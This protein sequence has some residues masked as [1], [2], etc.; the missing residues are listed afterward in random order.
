MC[1]NIAAALLGGALL[2]AG[3]A[4]Q[5]LA[6]PVARLEVER[7]ATLPL[8]VVETSGLA[9]H[10][11]RLWTHNDSGDEPRLYEIA[12]ASGEV[13]G[14]HPLRDALS[15]DWEE[16]AADEQWLHVL[17]CGNN[18]GQREW[19]QIYSVR[20]QSLQSA[21]AGEEIPG[22]LTEF[23]FA[24]REASSGA[25]AHNH[26]CEAAAVV[27]G[28]IWVFS[29]NWQDQHTRLYRLKS[30]QLRQTVEPVGRY[31]VNGLITAADYDPVRQRLVLLG[32]TKGR[33]SSS[34]F[35]WTFPVRDNMPDWRHAQ[36][37]NLAP[38]GQW[39]AVIW[40][41][42]GLLLTRESSLLGQAWLGFVA[43]P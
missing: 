13:L 42:D 28:Q 3:C 25:Y 37:Y 14:S 40:T 19:M 24:D 17:D 30:D 21:S 23:R 41:E 11:G 43:L 39:E 15:F 16:L 6:E 26:D 9:R 32:Y 27:N 12:P 33:I 10:E 5:Q 2:T 31:P 20:W 22:R 7:L 1:V 29:K 18:L 35:I 8:E 4:S 34:A 38:S 36:F